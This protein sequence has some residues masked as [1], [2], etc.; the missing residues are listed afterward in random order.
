MKIPIG[1]S[2]RHIHLS[3]EDLNILFGDNYQL[4]VDTQ[5]LQPLYFKAKERLTIKTDKN[6]IRDVA[7]VGPIREYTQVEISKTDSYA[8][9]INPPVKTS[10]DFEGAA[11]ITIIGPKNSITKSC[12]IISTRHI[13]MN[14]E[15]LN[16]FGL[17]PDQVVKVR[18]DTIKGGIMDNVYI[19]HDEEYQVEMHIDLDDANAHLLSNQD[20][21]YIIKE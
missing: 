12:C 18:V 19:R 2:A 9:G 11:S 21:G 3:Q 20:T 13:H 10:G 14:S 15:E 4:T 17:H 7:I 5:L 1:V 6:E 16:L 8:L